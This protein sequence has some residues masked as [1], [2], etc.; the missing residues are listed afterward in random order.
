[1]QGLDTLCSMVAH[2]FDI[3]MTAK[4]KDSLTQAPTMEGTDMLHIQKHHFIFG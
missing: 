1:M 2:S 4:N 3:R